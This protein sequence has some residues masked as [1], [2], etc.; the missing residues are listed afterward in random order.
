MNCS[1]TLLE[2]NNRIIWQI[3]RLYK[4]SN[5]KIL[6]FLEKDSMILM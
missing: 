5:K 3:N 1:I 4:I 6:K 2:Y